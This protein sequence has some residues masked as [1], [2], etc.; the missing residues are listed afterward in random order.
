MIHLIAAY[1]KGD[2]ERVRKVIKRHVEQI[3]EFDSNKAYRLMDAIATNG[4]QRF[5]DRMWTEAVGHRTPVGGL[6]TF[7]DEN[8]ADDIETVDLDD[9][10]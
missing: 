8:A 5:S 6:G 3:E 2:N 1:A 10:F 4:V 9:L 7:W